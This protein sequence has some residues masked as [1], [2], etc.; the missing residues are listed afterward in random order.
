MN[1][2]EAADLAKLLDRVNELLCEFVVTT[3]VERQAVIK[4]E[5]EEAVDKLKRTALSFQN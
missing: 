4:T 2:R 3:S 1:T 5:L